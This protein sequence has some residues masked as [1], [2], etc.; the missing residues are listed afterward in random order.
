MHDLK[1]SQKEESSSAF[2]YVHPKNFVTIFSAI[3]PKRAKIW[4]IAFLLGDKRFLTDFF[5]KELVLMRFSSRNIFRNLFKEPFF[6]GLKL[7]MPKN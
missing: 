7:K 5:T 6:S 1:K 3:V 2:L 4:P